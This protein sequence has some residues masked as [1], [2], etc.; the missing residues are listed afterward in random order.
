[1][2]IKLQFIILL[3]FNLT[4]FAIVVQPADSRSIKIAFSS[5][6]SG[7]HEIYTM[8]ID[9]SDLI[10]I[11]NY[12]ERDGYPACSPDGKN[13]AFYAYHGFPTWSIYKMD[14]DGNNR[15]RLTTNT[16]KWDNSPTWSPDGSKIAFSSQSLSNSEIW[17]MNSDGSNKLNLNV[18]GGGTYWAPD[19]Q[20]IFYHT[21]GGSDSEISVMDTDGT[22]QVQLTNN[23]S[24]DWHPSISPDGS[25]IAFMS[26]RDGNFEIYIMDI[27][28]SNPVRLTNDPAEDW[29][30]DW[31]PDGKKLAFTSFRDGN[32]EIYMIDAD[33]T[34]LVR[35]TNNSVDDL[36]V[37][38]LPDLAILNIRPETS[39]SKQINLLQN[40]PNP[41]NPNTTIWY[42]LPEGSNV[43][44]KI[45]N[46]LG[47]EIVEL[48]N[49]F[50]T[51][52][53]KSINWD[54]KDKNGNSVDSGV[55][56]YTFKSNN[57]SQTKK[58]MV[59]K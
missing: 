41:F 5:N 16:G 56:L 14:S 18:S 35:L 20:N 36:Q 12:N 57:F 28:A 26:D 7:N 50:Q 48:V 1:M 24:E 15:L 34:N 39:Q 17:I 10:K 45:Y 51:A 40:Y 30:P 33:G 58:M 42:E 25:K 11:T 3:V 55:Y 13:I 2:G 9:G 59:I 32:S 54:G 37:T 47:K 4:T 6:R 27:D 44:I 22:N 23:T 31:S 46:L 8:D 53:I 49:E 43:K 21:S 38:F 19:G 29:G 52:G